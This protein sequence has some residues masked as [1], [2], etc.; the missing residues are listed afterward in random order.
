[1]HTD[2]PPQELNRLDSKNWS[3]TPTTVET[4]L[5]NSMRDEANHLDA[6]IVLDQV[7]L[8]GTGVVT[9]G[10]QQQLSEIVQAYPALVMIADS[11]RGLQNW[12]AYISQAAIQLAR[13]TNRFVFI[14]LAER[15]LLGANPQGESVHVPAHAVRGPIDVVGAGDSVAANLAVALAA[16]ADLRAA[17][18]IAAAASSI[19]IHQLGTTGTA[20]IPQ[21]AEQLELVKQ[22]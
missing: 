12:P 10:M 8:A 14:T 15:G 20:S 6:M 21:I 19:V 22:I 16:Q 9:L 3:P 2:Q 5:V 7:D 4:C 13:H 17:L 1:M 11:R 18:E